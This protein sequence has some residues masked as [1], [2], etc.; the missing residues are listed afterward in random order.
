MPPKPFYETPEQMQVQINAY[1]KS[2][3]QTVTKTKGKGD[4]LTTWDE[5]IQTEAYTIPGINHYLGFS[6][7]HGM[8]DYLTGKP[9]FK[10]TILRAKLFIEKERNSDMLMAKNTRGYEFDLINNFGWGRQEAG[11]SEGVAQLLACLPEGIQV[12]ILAKITG[13]KP[14]THQ[15]ETQKVIFGDP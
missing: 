4:N 7:R 5:E 10:D 1:F 8:H 11:I 3:W 14:I 15:A 13:Q 9:P 12:M 2:C 6:T